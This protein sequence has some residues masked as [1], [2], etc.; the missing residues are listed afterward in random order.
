MPG[1]INDN[2]N[3]ISIKKLPFVTRLVTPTNPHVVHSL[4]AIFRNF[5]SRETRVS[6]ARATPNFRFGE[7]QSAKT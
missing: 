7:R 4:F 3:K 1:R 5:L 6:N 2:H